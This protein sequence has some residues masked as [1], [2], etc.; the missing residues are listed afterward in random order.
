MRRSALLLLIALSVGVI[1]AWLPATDPNERLE[2][3]AADLQQR[4]GERYAELD[5]TTVT[6]TGSFIPAS[7]PEGTHAWLFEADS[8]LWW[9]GTSL[10]NEDSARALRNGSTRI[11][12]SVYLSASRGDAHD[13]VRAIAALWVRPPFVNEYL[14]P[15]FH[16]S[17]NTPAGLVAEHGPGIGPVVRDTN[18]AV[19][20]RLAWSDEALLIGPREWIRIV[21]WTLAFVLLLVV[22]WRLCSAVAQPLIS[23]AAFASSIIL[24]RITSVLL[25]P[26]EPFDRFA[27]FGPEL[28]AAS[29]WL[30][31]LGD[32]L[33]DALL[34]AAIA[35][36]AH[37]RT[38]KPVERV[39]SLF[40]SIASCAL[41]AI[42]WWITDTFIGL[43]RDSSVDLDLF[44]LQDLNG[45]SAVAL[46][47][48][49][50]LFGGWA[51]LVDAIARRVLPASAPMR[52]I[53]VVL[54]GI[55]LSTWLHD[56]A[57]IVDMILVWW[58]VPMIAIVAHGR[59]KGFRIGHAIAGVSVIA[60]LG[61]HVLIKY[62]GHRSEHE[63][64]ALAERSITSD[65]P[66]VELLFREAAPRLRN[67]TAVYALLRDSAAC[68]A[69]L[70]D[71]RVRQA[72]FTGY[73]E[74][75]DVR[76]YAF[77]PDG[78]PRCATSTEAPRS[79]GGDATAF[80]RAFAAVDMPELFIDTAAGRRTFYHAR[81][82]VMASDT[83]PPAQVVIELHPR[84][85]VDALGYPELLLNDPDGALRRIGRYAFARYEGGML[86]EQR[87]AA[88]P[89][90]WERPVPGGPWARSTIAGLDAI[91]YGD[92]ATSL[93]VIATPVVRWLDRVTLF[94]WLFAFLGALL[95]AVLLVRAV[96]RRGRVRSIG[97]SQRVRLALLLFAL[98]GI[99]MFSFGAQWLVSRLLAERS[100]AD[101]QEHARSV[102]GE[103]RGRLDGLDR[104]TNDDGAYLQHLLV[105]LSGIFFTDVNLYRPDGGLLATSRPQV[106]D[107]GLVGRRMDASAFSAMALAGTSEFVHDESIGRARFRSAYAPLRNARGRLLALVNLPSFARQ[108][109]ADRE[110]GALFTATVNLLVLLLAL[111]LLAGLFI[112]GSITRPLELLKRG[113]SRIALQGANEPIAYSGHDEV[114]E[115]VKVYNR[116]VEEL[117]ESADRLARSERESAWKEMARQV[118]HEIKNPLTPMR[119]SVQHF[120]RTWDPRDAD[121]K[122]KLERFTTGMVQQIDALSRIAGEFSA[123]AQMPP[124]QETVFDLREVANAGVALFQGDANTTIAL[125]ASEPLPVNADRD[126]LLRALNNL[127]KNALQAIPEGRHARIDVTLVRQGTHAVLS[128]T[129][130]GTG[131]PE[132]VR[133]R[134]F[135]PSFTTKSSG[136][137]LGL[138][139]VK[140]I[141]EQARGR[142]WFETAGER[143]TTFRLLLP[144]HAGM[145]S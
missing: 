55:A 10:L 122:D 143:G 69:A 47:C 89:M 34:F 98:V 120:E 41:L 36:F 6:I 8:L 135:D 97:L 96:L 44:H 91:A 3:A 72:W 134:I 86:V 76:L 81:V 49:A 66:V 13:G 20:F 100:D 95:G 113:L 111:S 12:N 99:G 85:G 45:Y 48:V 7:L 93:V 65:D 137:G 19:L 57:G 61:A 92:P 82:A 132:E 142:V 32:L 119:L 25:Y 2:N 88:F 21:C 53:A 67:D 68:T 118:A 56:R 22:L 60:F 9:S 5:R 35:G 133:D 127:L 40:L 87:G 109:E 117:R 59:W 63:R 17:F 78:T 136:M 105:R 112:S 116:K 101:L 28:Y 129:D 107:A 58:P 138:A 103:L 31:S 104:L 79:L 73:W 108:G 114:G 83:T 94:S 110:R 14:R 126:H 1:A 128:V 33:V 80:S 18:G 4:I 144:L 23:T 51:L 11:G 140:R 39:S 84:V 16:P 123:F 42:G 90:H 145:A 26:I 27:L 70:L 38:A 75:Y 15:A 124:A 130:N 37:T 139:M 125:T 131:I 115:L 29:S 62:T 121:A 77:G 50:F 24:L 141:A 43:V 71:E 102:V 54:A 30:P 46:M 74:R 106:F 64:T 52:S